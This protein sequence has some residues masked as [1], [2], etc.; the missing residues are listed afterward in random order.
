VE[1]REA[2]SVSSTGGFQSTRVN[3]N[4]LTG[5][6][7]NRKKSDGVRRR[8][9]QQQESAAVAQALGE[10]LGDQQPLAMD[11]VEEGDEAELVEPL[12][13][14][15]VRVT[16]VPGMDVN[17]VIAEMCAR[18]PR[19]KQPVW[20]TDTET[21]GKFTRPAKAVR[22]VD[23]D[24]LSQEGKFLVEE[25]IPGEFG[26]PQRRF[27]LMYSQIE[28]A[29]TEGYAAIIPS[30]LTTEPL[31]VTG[32]DEDETKRGITSIGVL[33]LPGSQ[34]EQERI[35][36]EELERE[37]SRAEEDGASISLGS[38]VDRKVKISQRV[39][40]KMPQIEEWVK[41]AASSAEYQFAI[42][43]YPNNDKGISSLLFTL[44]KYFKDY[45]AKLRAEAG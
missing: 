31:E 30:Q 42:T 28:K 19:L 34:I 25:T 11:N 2:S 32:Y 26:L 16:G 7:L 22:P 18:E 4:L 10:K 24:A 23:F 38:V 36:R 3:Q 14:N 45:E 33:V 44:G 43:D 13:L 8:A 5:G 12:K 6:R 41:V 1:K 27:G 17:A 35:L 21:S 37:V 15:V 29:A 20:V 40:E 39:L 9:I